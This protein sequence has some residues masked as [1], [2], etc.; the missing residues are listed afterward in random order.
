MKVL[1]LMDEIIAE[2]ENSK[3][4]MFSSKRSIDVDFVL[5]ILDEIR[6]NLPAELAEAKEIVSDRDRIIEKAQNKAKNIMAGVD[7]KL[8]EMIEDHRVT[9][10]AYEKSNRILDAAQRQAYELRVNANDY[11]VNVLDDIASYMKEYTDIIRENKSNF[12]NNKNKDQA[13]F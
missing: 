6:E 8:S 4:S 12:I 9:Q 3:K 11:A 1:E 5:D 13:E 2:I 10:L 7:V